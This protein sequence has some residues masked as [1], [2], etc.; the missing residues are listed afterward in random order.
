MTMIDSTRLPPTSYSL[1][2]IYWQCW[3]SVVC[4]SQLEDKDLLFHHWP[5]GSNVPRT[6]H[7]SV[8]FC[9]K[10]LGLLTSNHI[11]FFRYLQTLTPYYFYF[12]FFMLLYL[13]LVSLFRCVILILSFL[14][15]CVCM[16]IGVHVNCTT[17]T[18]F[19]KKLRVY[20]R[21]KNSTGPL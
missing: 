21:R 7:L 2:L 17:L 9:H 13:Y 12:I 1:V 8:T 6:C 15:F 10:E 5:F 3:K 4:W 16:C 20:T 11:Y 14:L 18:K 19:N